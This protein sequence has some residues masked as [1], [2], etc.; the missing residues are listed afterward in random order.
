MAISTRVI[1][2]VLWIVSLLGVG[3]ITHAQ[4]QA[5]EL[6]RLPEP[7]IM[8]GGDVGFRVEGMYGEMPT[9]TIVI[10][11]YGQWVEAMV[12]TPG[13]VSRLWLKKP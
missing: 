10:R 2:A 6:R 4:S 1:V 5:K 12:G 3:A 7:R 9:G 13:A 11:V 8:T